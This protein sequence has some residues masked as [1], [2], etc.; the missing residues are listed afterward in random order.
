MEDESLAKAVK[1]IGYFKQISGLGM[2][3]NKNKIV[4]L[5]SIAHSDFKCTSGKGLK[6]SE[7]RVTS[8]SIKLSGETGKM[9]DLNYPEKIKKITTCLNVW[10]L[11]GLSNVRQG[12]IREISG[13]IQVDI[14]IVHISLH[15][16]KLH[17]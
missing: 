16:F 17:G 12:T 11:K 6:W 7:A 14:S 3:K 13:Y 9:P 15:L 4:R 8:L 2:N 1:S 10:N 5:G